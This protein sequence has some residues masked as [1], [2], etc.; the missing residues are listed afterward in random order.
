MLASPGQMPEGSGWGFEFKWDG[1]R[2]LVHLDGKGGLRLVSRTGKDVTHWFPELAAVAGAVDGPA[3]LDGEVVCLDAKGRPDFGLIQQR[4]NKDKDLDVRTAMQAAP[5][6]LLLFDVLSLAGADLTGKTYEQR[7]KALD[8]LALK[9]EHWSTPPWRK[10]DGAAMLEASQ[11]L[12]LEGIVAKKLASKYV[13][14]ERSDAWVKVRNR[15]RQEF[16]VGGW[17][18]GEGS[19]RG[20]FGALL[21]GHYPKRGG[22]S[23]KFI[24]RVGT[25]FDDDGLAAMKKALS[26]LERKAC[27]FDVVSIAGDE[28]GGVRHW[29]EPHLVAEVEFSGLTPQGHLRQ[30]S[31]KGLRP[32]KPADEVIWEQVDT[33][34]TDGET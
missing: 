32:D 5:A 20:S 1:M 27:P 28:A 13:A 23:L 25:G 18:A 33:G 7:R 6:D 4:F 29:V 26:I 34:D 31:F 17:S 12:G 9:G 24:G 22:G 30:A 2:A 21:L 3:V 8:G 16:V 11:S 14:G 19:R 10:G 15:H